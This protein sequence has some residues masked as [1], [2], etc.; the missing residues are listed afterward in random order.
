MPI[1]IL[2]A[3]LTTLLKYNGGER[4][5]RTLGTVAR[6]HAFQACSFN[7]SDISPGYLNQYTVLMAERVGF[8]PTR[9]VTAYSISSRAPS[10]SSATSP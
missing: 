3:L 10:T 5:I 8:E 2:S 4:G 7:R 6:T 1:K 9:P